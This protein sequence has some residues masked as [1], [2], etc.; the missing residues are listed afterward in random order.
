[1]PGAQRGLRAAQLGAGSGEPLAGSTFAVR[2]AGTAAVGGGQTPSHGPAWCSASPVQG[3]AVRPAPG[4]TGFVIASP[5]FPPWASPTSAGPPSVPPPRRGVS[6]GSPHW[7]ARSR[8]PPPASAARLDAG[9]R[10]GSAS[11][12]DITV[13]PPAHPALALLAPQGLRH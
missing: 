8:S 9:A 12:E 11:E 4:R 5:P 1:M 7:R 3:G 13:C 6:P 2:A 10:Q